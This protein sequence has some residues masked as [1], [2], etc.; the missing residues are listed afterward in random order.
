M[1]DVRAYALKALREQRVC[2]AHARSVPNREATPFEVLARVQGYH[3]VYIVGY[4][5]GAWSCTCGKDQPCGHRTA[6]G[7]ATGHYPQG[8][9]VVGGA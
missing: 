2:V 9:P 4:R 3:G 8:L 6:V 7:L 5:G 1:S